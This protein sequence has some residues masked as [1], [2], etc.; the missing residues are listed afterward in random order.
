MDFSRG[1]SSAFRV[2]GLDSSWSEIGQ[3]GAV[4]SISITR[5]ASSDAPL[6]DSADLDLDAP[7][8]D[9][10]YV[11]V[12][13]DATQDGS[14]TSFPLGT[15]LLESSGGETGAGTDWSTAELWSVLK[16]ADERKLPVGWYAHKG[17][18][19]ASKAASLLGACIDAPVEVEP[20]SPSLA[21][22]Y[23]SDG[24]KTYLAV[25]W[26]LLP[27]GWTIATDGYGNVRV[28]ETEKTPYAVQESEVIGTVKE[29]W[30]LA[31]VPNSIT[32]SDDAGNEY[33]VVNDDR[34]SPTST[35]ARGRVIDGDGSGARNSGESLRSFAR[36]LL[37]EQSKVTRTCTYERE[38]RS[39][40][41]V[42]DMVTIPG[43]Y[44]TW[45]VT[46]QSLTCGCGVTV[47]ETAVREESTWR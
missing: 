21:D 32:V 3:I 26:E 19:A 28:M 9:E 40:I 42:G 13:M 20:G 29:S 27:D 5:D 37:S 7:A 18:V 1:Y 31:G 30:D 6:L 39:D 41:D 14:T 38:Y 2:V 44:G 25:A 22:H 23:V 16:P 4:T 47:S 43:K 45:R 15:F 24:T 36:R 17:A 34:T 46:G 8:V 10:S 11:R 35:V 12:Y 33:T